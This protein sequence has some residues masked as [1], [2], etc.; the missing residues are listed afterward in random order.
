MTKKLTGRINHVLLAL[1]AVQ[2]IIDLPFFLD[3][4]LPQ[5]DTRYAFELFYFSY[6]ELLA[7]GELPRWIP[8]GFFGVQSDYFIL[9][10]TDYVALFIGKLLNITDALTA[11]KLSIFMGQLVYLLGIYLLAER[12]FKRKAT[13]FIVSA[14]SIS[15]MVLNIQLHQNFASFIYLPLI[16]YFLHKFF[17]DYKARYL[18][19]AA[20]IFVLSLSGIGVYL[21]T[22]PAMVITIFSFTLA[23]VSIKKWRKF[24]SI[25]SK[26]AL[27]CGFFS[28]T[29]LV[30]T[31]IYLTFLTG[32][33]EETVGIY[34]GR[35][36]VTKF[37]T[38]SSYL[39]YATQSI[40]FW[41]FGGLVYPGG[42]YIINDITLHV[43]FLTL[44]FS[45]YS[46]LLVRNA[47]TIAFVSI[48]AIFTLFSLGSMTPLAEFLYNYF[49]TMKYFRGIGNSVANFKL[50]LPLL[51]GFGIDH[52]LG[53]FNTKSVTG[54][55]ARLG[56]SVVLFVTAAV[57]LGGGIVYY[58]LLDR[59]RLLIWTGL[60]VVFLI[61][62]SLLQRRFPKKCAPWFFITA[63]V[64]LQAFSYR[65]VVTKAFIVNFQDHAPKE[66][67]R[68]IRK[69]PFEVERTAEPVSE[70]S[71]AT[72]PYVMN[73]TVRYTLVF[74]FLQWDPC[75]S[76][77]RTD[78]LNSNVAAL[79]KAGK[80]PII[81]LGSTETSG[82]RLYLPEDRGFQRAMG[83]FAPKLKLTSNVLF[84]DS[85]EES[86][87]LVGEGMDIGRTLIL[88]DVALVTKS[89]WLDTT[90]KDREEVTGGKIDIKSF[91]ANELSLTADVD[92]PEGLWLYY[93]DGWH[94]SWKAYLNGKE[95]AIVKAN[96]GFKAIKLEK[97]R[98]EVSFVY[99]NKKS[100]FLL[101][102]IILFD[103]IL[104][105]I[106][107]FV[108]IRKLFR[109][110]ITSEESEEDNNA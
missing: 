30:V 14:V 77:F 85:I 3:I 26:E 48:I 32:A 63:C 29:F 90:D 53:L 61:I 110:A 58:S 64:L 4:V 83:C 28:I 59:D 8:F 9:M 84:S 36:P 96:I 39:N 81:E 78:F 87:R 104:L 102:L 107:G 18:F 34:T 16:L 51:A 91:S 55:K 35:D 93:A 42:D 7:F 33:L 20:N 50:F 99:K 23:L 43:G 75:V 60:T 66:I 95:S 86:A 47:V 100:K 31:F 17:T 73:S 72:M 2:I 103:L 98:N 25:T 94:P 108:F 21:A 109:P 88:N 40:G 27:I 101:D 22:L 5:H 54:T 12:L 56:G 80:A 70:R 62:L 46:L 24:T 67:S 45:I 79:L 41:K 105:S 69:Y 57:T 97:G 38:L 1:I 74:S 71:A 19:I 92:R 15:S 76:F 49:P 89:S 65:A 13:V 6:N 52:M 10:P 82:K 106:I 11:F 44:F 68:T 37:S